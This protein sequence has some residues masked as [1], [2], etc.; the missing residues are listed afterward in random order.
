MHHA[1]TYLFSVPERPSGTFDSYQVRVW[2]TDTLSSA[3]T[4][5][6]MSDPCKYKGCGA[7]GNCSPATGQCDCVNG[8]TGA[9]CAIS[10]CAKAGCVQSV[11]PGV[12]SC[13]VND[14]Y[15]AECKCDDKYYE[16]DMCEH[17]KGCAATCENGGIAEIDLSAVG[18]SNCGRCL[19]PRGTDWSGDRC[20]TCGL[21]CK[22]GQPN[23]DCSA[24]ECDEGYFGTKC[25]CKSSALVMVPRALVPPRWRVAFRVS[26]SACGVIQFKHQPSLH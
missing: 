21:V 23:A 24:C 4:S 25:R 6:K 20:E 17:I 16:G 14:T 9:A 7:N 26:P 10:P 1:G 18:E 12:A 11:H 15:Y 8:Y 2:H 3:T 5:F 22:N 13:D 19:C